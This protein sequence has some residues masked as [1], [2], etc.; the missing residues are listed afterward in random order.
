MNNLLVKPY[1]KGFAITPLGMPT[2]AQA[3]VSAR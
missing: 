1:V 3:S 2:L